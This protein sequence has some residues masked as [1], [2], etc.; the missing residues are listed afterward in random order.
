MIRDLTNGMITLMLAKFILNDVPH[1]MGTVEGYPGWG[2]L[3]N[4]ATNWGL[5][6]SEAVQQDL[7]D[8]Q[9]T[10]VAVH[11]YKTVLGGYFLIASGKAPDSVVNGVYNVI[12]THVA[13]D[14][15]ITYDLYPHGGF[16]IH[17]AVKRLRREQ[18]IPEDAPILRMPT[19]VGYLPALERVLWL[20]RFF[21]NGTRADKAIAID[22]AMHM[23][24]DEGSYIIVVLGQ[25]IR[26]GAIENITPYV[27]EELFLR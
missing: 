14:M 27:L 15:S 5:S 3:L 12:K 7:A 9:V 21:V 25:D 19:G 4:F 16:T 26:G 10:Q 22:T 24:H 18:G 23:V 17:E 6:L 8:G 11:N 2:K 1:A 20:N 13:Y